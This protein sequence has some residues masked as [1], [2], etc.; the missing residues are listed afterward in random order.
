MSRLLRGRSR[1]CCESRPTDTAWLSST[2]L[3]IASAETET[4]S[5]RPP[6]S[7]FASTRWAAP[8][9]T[10]TPVFSYFLKLVVTISTR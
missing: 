7:S 2:M 6:S 4:V 1:S 8:V 10:T 5:V 3:L 9:R